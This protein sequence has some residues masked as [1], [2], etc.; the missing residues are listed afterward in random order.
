MRYVGSKARMV[1]QRKKVLKNGYSK[2]RYI[3]MRQ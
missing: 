2:T 3:G 1:R